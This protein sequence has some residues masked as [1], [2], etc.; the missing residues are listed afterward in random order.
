MTNWRNHLTESER[1]ELIAIDRKIME[2]RHED[3]TNTAA[4]ELIRRRAA[5]RMRR[6]RANG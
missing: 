6:E 5:A 1:I 2:A 4:R 3:S